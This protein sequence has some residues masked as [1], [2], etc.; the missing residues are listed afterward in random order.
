MQ[1]ERKLQ[2]VRDSSG[3]DNPEQQRTILLTR[4]DALQHDID[5][6]TA[7]KAAT[8]SSIA[9]LDKQLAAIPANQVI[10]EGSGAA[11]DSLDTMRTKL[12]ELRLDEADLSARYMPGAPPLQIIQDKISQAEKE[13]A[14]ASAGEAEKTVGINHTYEELNIRRGNELANQASLQSRIASLESAKAKAQS[15]LAWIDEV[16]VK[17]ES[18]EQQTELAAANVTKY[19]GAYEQARID[20][21]MGQHRI[22]NI[23]VA[24]P[25]VLPLT[26]KG[27]GRGLIALSGLFMALCLGIGSVFVA[28][29]VDHTVRRAEHLRGLGM[30]RVVSIPYVRDYYEPF[31]RA[32]TLARL[33]AKATQGPLGLEEMEEE[34]VPVRPLRAS[35][36][37]AL[38]RRSS[39]WARFSSS[40]KI[41]FPSAWIG[42]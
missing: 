15:G 29:S 25:P 42:D 24:E 2:E 19:A 12:A 26:P 9:E 33:A 17:T 13:L 1:L 11:M 21:E 3:V 37:N 7:D 22:S 18:L 35:V 39:W 23:S 20:Q 6:A 5:A 30:P 31:K 36:R 14:E 10:Q 38:L 8:A 40:S 28:E 34:S 4:V 41:E 16:G 32:M 27:P